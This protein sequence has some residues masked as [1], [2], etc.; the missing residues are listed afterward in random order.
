L[1]RQNQ[2]IADDLAKLFPQDTVAQYN[3]LPVIRAQI[4]LA[5]G[6]PAK[7]IA[8]LE[9]ASPYEMGTPAEQVFLNVYPVYARGEAPVWA[10][11]SQRPRFSA[12]NRRANM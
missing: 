9:P 5:H 4:A 3:Y 11:R 6:D 1:L 10:E 8:L 12:A 2:A 7:A